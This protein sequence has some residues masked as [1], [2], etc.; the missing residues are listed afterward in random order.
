MIVRW[1]WASENQLKALEI[2][3]SLS[4]VDTPDQISLVLN[5]VKKNEFTPT[6][7]IKTLRSQE[8]HR[9]IHSSVKGSMKTL[10]SLKWK[11]A[12]LLIIASRIYKYFG[13]WLQKL[14]PLLCRAKEHVAQS[15]AICWPKQRNNQ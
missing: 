6:C 5:N 7:H 2:K 8:I 10:Q 12:S 13:S 3:K 4:L 11:N 14:V 1:D 9:K 15:D